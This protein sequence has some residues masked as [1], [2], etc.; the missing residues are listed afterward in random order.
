[1]AVTPDVLSQTPANFLY[2]MDALSDLMRVVRFTGGMYL[3]SK[4]RA[5]WC[6]RAQISSEDCTPD[7]K[8]VGSLVAFHYV[9]EGAVQVRV[10]NNK[11]KI[12]GPGEIILLSRND[13][14]LMG[15]DLSLEP[16]DARPL[17]RKAEKEVVAHLEFGKGREIKSRF[18]CGFL[19][20]A[21]SDHP[22]LAAL[23]PLLVADL[24]QQPSAEW[25]DSSFRYAAREHASRRPASQEVLA[26]LSE[27]LF[28][29]AVREYVAK[30]PA[31]AGG[32]LAAMRDPAL[33]RT[34]T[35]LHRRPAHAWT[36]EELA[37][38]ARLSRSAFAEKFTN[39]VGLAPKSYLT[40]W[41]IQLA[42]QRL[43]ESND[44]LAQVAAKVGYESEFS[45]SRAFAR[46]TGVAPGVWRKNNG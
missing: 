32:W 39:T 18:V 43:R 38:E 3:E 30:L 46:E 31:N 5:P 23:P 4:F 41:R 7:I 37:K 20:T 27:M 34:L 28:V 25:A 8:A 42:G 33:S 10:K 44:T 17:I 40:R 15:S 6:V 2:G 45:F 13:P 35:A 16:V 14:H 19:A 26:R 11:P 29:E 24:S 22:L 36:T 12:A 21:M 9:L 1:M